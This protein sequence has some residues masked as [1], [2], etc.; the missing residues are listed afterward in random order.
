M[1]E[2]LNSLI[3]NQAPQGDAYLYRALYHLGSQ[4]ADA[5]RAFAQN[6]ADEDDEEDGGGT[7]V[8]LPAADWAVVSVET[9]PF[10]TLQEK[11][12]ADAVWGILQFVDQPGGLFALIDHASAKSLIGLPAN[13]RFTDE[14]LDTIDEVVRRLSLV[15][16]EQWA[17]ILSDTENQHGTFPEMPDLSELQEIFMGLV[18]STPIAAITFRTTVPSQPLGRVMFAIPQPYLVPYADSLKVAAD[19]THVQ[20]GGEDMDSRLH[21]LGD[22][23]TPVVAYLGATSMTVAELQS[24]EEEDVIVLDQTATDPLVVELGGGARIL[25][26]PGTSPDG[27]RKAVQ[28][29]RLGAD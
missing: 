24:L 11:Y 21:H 15:F 18:T 12:G 2:D 17:D 23:P 6:E 14:H 4:M 16:G 8:E 9:Y 27:L 25:A 13:R 19:Y 22:V 5:M 20:T 7:G 10:A 29:V 3:M 26:K 28:I 1:S